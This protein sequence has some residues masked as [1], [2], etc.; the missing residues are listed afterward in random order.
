M[1]GTQFVTDEKGRKVQ[2]VEALEIQ[3]KFRARAEKMSEAQGGVARDGASSVEYLRHT[4]R[5]NV[6]LARQFRRAHVQLFQLLSQFGKVPTS[7][8]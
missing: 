2:L 4:I 6:D 7:A 1:S 8:I 5:G 3:P